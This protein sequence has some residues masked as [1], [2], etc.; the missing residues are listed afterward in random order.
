MASTL[1]LVTELN[2]R[3]GLLHFHHWRERINVN[4]AIQNTRNLR[5]LLRSK[6]KIWNWV[7]GPLLGLERRSSH[8]PYDGLYYNCSRE[9]FF[10]L[11]TD[12]IS[13]PYDHGD[14]VKLPWIVC[15]QEPGGAKYRDAPGPEYVP[16]AA[17]NP[18]AETEARILRGPLLHGRVYRDAVLAASRKGSAM[19]TEATNAAA[20]APAHKKGLRD[21][22]CE[23]CLADAA[24]ARA[25]E[26][27]KVKESAEGSYSSY[28]SRLGYFIRD[29][30][31]HSEHAA[32]KDEDIDAVQVANAMA[33]VSVSARQNSTGGAAKGADGIALPALQ[34]T[35][36]KGSFY[37]TDWG[38]ESLEHWRQA[39]SKIR[40]CTV[41]AEDKAAS[42]Y[43][44]QALSPDCKHDMS[45]CTQCHEVW[46]KNDLESNSYN[47]ASCPECEN[48]LPYEAVQ[49]YADPASFAKY[50]QALLRLAIGLE[51]AFIY[52]KS[53]SCSSGQEHTGGSPLFHCWYCGFRWCLKHDQRWHEEQSCVE[54][55]AD[56]D[57]RARSARLARE[58]RAK[59]EA[60]SK[61]EVERSSKKCPGPGCHHSI[62]RT[63]GCAAMTCS[64][65]GYRFCWEC[66]EQDA[67]ILNHGNRAHKAWCPHYR[68]YGQTDLQW[69]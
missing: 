4:A 50:D 15:L 20:A 53:P 7:T 18:A 48:N 39:A 63:A 46:I 14:L 55:D 65:C 24:N 10:E 62:Q 11:N 19:D 59:E 51:A 68:T 37:D 49:R 61:A 21:S 33:G 38:E 34:A 56:P 35:L 66:L 36:Q 41:C 12:L 29:N 69:H 23:G 67:K 30:M 25:A 52:C 43:P 16:T 54:F 13:Q 42:D 44:Q 17:S 32:Q 2:R 28:L 31:I 22:K 27:V 40:T 58:A 57:W 1:P 64:S 5:D 8:A 60:A 47:R 3:P 6:D 9:A 26:Q 45:C